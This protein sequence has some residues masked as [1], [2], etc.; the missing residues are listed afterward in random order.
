MSW[1]EATV[2]PCQVKVREASSLACI[3]YLFHSPR[4]NHC[5]RFPPHPLAGLSNVRNIFPWKAVVTQSHGIL[6][7]SRRWLLALFYETGQ[8]CQSYPQAELSPVSSSS[9]SQEGVDRLQKTL[10]VI[11]ESDFCLTKQQ[12][13]IPLHIMAHVL[14]EEQGI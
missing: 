12:A 13:N 4:P 1:K 7:Y 3:T 11:I 5:Y 8:R 9:R 14:P 10:P 6:P 2:F